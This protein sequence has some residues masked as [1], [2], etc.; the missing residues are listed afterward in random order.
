VIKETVLLQCYPNPFNPETWIPY[1]LKKEAEVKI[2]LYNVS[3]QL[4]RT[5]ELGVQSR[6]RYISKQKAAH[7]DGRDN[8]GERVASGVYYY[9]LQARDFRKTRKMVIVK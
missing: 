2:D 6:G 8:L 4:V 5:L 9:T 7:W 1:E 3:G